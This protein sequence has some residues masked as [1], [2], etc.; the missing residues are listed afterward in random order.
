MYTKHADNINSYLYTLFRSVVHVHIFFMSMLGTH[1]W[2]RKR[3]VPGI[4]PGA[5]S[6]QRRNH[7][8][9]PN[10][11]PDHQLQLSTYNNAIQWYYVEH[12]IKSRIYLYQTALLIKWRW[13]WTWNNSYTSSCSAYFVLNLYHGG[14]NLMALLWIVVFFYCL[15]NGKYH[16]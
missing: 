5:S 4:E 3:S 6:T 1:I 10:G 15:S 7:A 16:C 13:R 12:L 14:C 9:R 2:T 8:A 11:L